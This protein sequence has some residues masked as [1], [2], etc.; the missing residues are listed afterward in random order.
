MSAMKKQRKSNASL[1][2]KKRQ[3]AKNK[4]LR[5]KGIIVPENNSD[6]VTSKP[7]SLKYSF[8]TI[9]E[10]RYVII[11]FDKKEPVKTDSIF[12]RYNSDGDDVLDHDKQFIKVYLDSNK[13]D[14]ISLIKVREHFGDKEEDQNQNRHTSVTKEHIAN[15]LM[16][17]G[18]PREKIR[19]SHR[20]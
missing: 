2:K 5:E 19:L 18:V 9:K 20:K 1:R 14:N 6:E 15:F 12:V 16:K 17:L 3:R 10:D 8:S 13:I 11:S 7:D 4:R